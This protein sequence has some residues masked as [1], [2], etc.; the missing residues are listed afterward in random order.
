[1]SLHVI[2]WSHRRSP[3]ATFFVQIIHQFSCNCQH[4]FFVLRSASKVMSLAQRKISESPPWNHIE[5]EIWWEGKSEKHTLQY[6]LW[7]PMLCL[8]TLVASWFDAASRCF[9]EIHLY[10]AL[11]Y[12]FLL[13]GELEEWEAQLTEFEVRKGG[14]FDMMIRWDKHVNM[15]LWILLKMFRK[16]CHLTERSFVKKEISGPLGPGNFNIVRYPAIPIYFN[17]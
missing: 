12:T 15:I 3:L 10:F 6:V 2:T 8:Q 9:V 14:Q 13:N 5:R 7:E 16:D 17:F 1:M 4:V 11:L